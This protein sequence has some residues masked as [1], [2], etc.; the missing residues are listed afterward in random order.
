MKQLITITAIVFLLAACKK[1]K[2]N[3]QNNQTTNNNNSGINISHWLPEKPFWG[4]A[5][6]IYGNGFS[7][8]TSDVEVYLLDSGDWS[9]VD[10]SLYKAQVLSSTA[11]SITV[12]APYNFKDL[13][14]KLMP[15]NNVGYGKITVIQKNKGRYTTKESIFFNAPPYIYYITNLTTNNN[16]PKVGCKLKMSGE[17]FGLT[18]TDFSLYVNNIKVDIDSVW[19]SVN[20]TTS[21]IG[22]KYLTFILPN[23]LGK[24]GQVD[25][26]TIFTYKI[27]RNGHEDTLA[28]I[29][30]TSVVSKVTSHTMPTKFY[31]AGSTPTTQSFKVFGENLY[32]NTVRFSP[33]T[34][35]YPSA[36]V[37]LSGYINATEKDIV[38][39]V[40]AITTSTPSQGY[41]GGYNV[42][43]YDSRNGNSKILGSLTIYP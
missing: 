14:S 33:T 3:P 21:G 30:R 34:S 29:T 13:G 37:A 41:Y 5:F 26:D 4:D 12:R 16:I 42:F 1:E 31:C 28:K 25:D 43:L 17:G 11:T 9:Q 22:S 36:S 20:T 35:G 40:N 24:V 27:V 18:K 39:P 15:W 6:T 7:A 10:T 23:S 8:N 32:Y 19:G 38:I 2:T